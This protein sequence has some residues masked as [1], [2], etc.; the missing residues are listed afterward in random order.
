MQ[1]YLPIAEIPV[2]IFLILALGLLTGF[3]A[4]MFG[5]GGGFLATPFLIFIG[6]PSPVAVSTSTNQIIAASI[7]GLLAHFKK[8]N[9][10]IKMGLFLVLGGIIGS[11]IGVSIFSILK[12]AGQIDLVIAITYVLFLGSISIM[13]LSD[14]FR[15]FIDKKFGM[16]WHRRDEEEVKFKWLLKKID[17]LPFKTYFSR[18]E[19][20]VS[21]LV[22]ITLSF[23][24]GILV[25]LMGVGGGFLMIP[26]MLYILRMPS[27]LVVGT[28]LFQIVFIASNA[29]FLQAV[30]G[31]NVDL[32]LGVL[33]I[34]SSA[35]GA[36][37]GSRA[38]YKVDANATRTFL[39]I[40][41]L[42]ICFKMMF[43]LFSQPSNIYSLDIL[44]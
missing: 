9:V 32:V 1:I 34:L 28:S 8:G 30:T 40:L 7:S 35:I 6:V 17:N 20:Y 15:N 26:A 12:N 44:K 23:G 21:V 41:L 18:S 33:M 13:M 19:I 29:T 11:S 37:F 2:N 25:S 16:D 4:G 38:A 10:D 42:L 31:N 24:I 27:S 14:S 36:Q 3:L 5:I 43:Q 39:A 22:P